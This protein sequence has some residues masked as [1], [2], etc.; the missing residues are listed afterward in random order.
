MLTSETTVSAWLTDRNAVVVVLVHAVTQ[1]GYSIMDTEM[2]G[3]VA[4]VTGQSV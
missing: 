1:K 2:Y 4:E 3:S